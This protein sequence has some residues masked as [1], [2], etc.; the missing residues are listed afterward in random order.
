[1]DLI[2]YCIVSL[3]TKFATYSQFEHSAA[4]H[5][6]LSLII[7]IVAQYTTRNERVSAMF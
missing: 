7:N 5:R 6:H 4:S 1:M 3:V 2:S